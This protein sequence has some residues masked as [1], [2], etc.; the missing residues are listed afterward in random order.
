MENWS[1]LVIIISKVKTLQ[2]LHY[3]LLCLLMSSL[4]KD[5]QRFLLSSSCHCS[6][7]NL[8]ICR[9]FMWVFFGN[10]WSHFWQGSS[11]QENIRSMERHWFVYYNSICPT[12]QRFPSQGKAR[13][14]T[15]AAVAFVFRYF[16]KEKT[17]AT[18]AWVYLRTLPCDGKHWK[19]GQ[20]LL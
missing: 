8:D 12:Y 19:V 2:V 14:Q 11:H 7:S 20:M 9:Y 18:A 3:L 13:R 17:N 10:V 6:K 5:W 15:Q 16:W 1:C 4:I